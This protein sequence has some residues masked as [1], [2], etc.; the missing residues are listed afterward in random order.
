VGAALLVKRLARRAAQR[1]RGYVRLAF[2]NLGG[3]GSLAPV[4]APAL[5]LG[6]AL[7]VLVSVVQTNLLGQLRDTAP[8]NAPSIIFRQIPHGDVGSFDALM[9]AEGVD[10]DDADSY[11]R[12]PFILGRVIALKG[13]PLNEATVS[14][15]ERW[16]VRG[17]TGMTFLGE[18][19]AEVVIRSG[20]W[21][22]PDYRGPQL[23]SVEEGAA[24]G[25]GLR[26][27]DSIG[28]R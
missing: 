26:V 4:V 13:E 21:W 17:E 10:V 22:P 11:R 18:R 7:M 25:L 27:G 1:S 15:E 23:V 6:L 3:P 12:A 19:P 2:A 14:P 16:V 24:R 8:A 5:G 28:F 20:E 9:R